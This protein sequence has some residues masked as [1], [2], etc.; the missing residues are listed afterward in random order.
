M[1]LSSER[2]ISFIIFGLFVFTPAI[3]SWQSMNLANWYAYYAIWIALI[4]V[5]AWFQWML[6]DNESQD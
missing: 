2:L 3:N 1:M 4:M 5:C 6:K